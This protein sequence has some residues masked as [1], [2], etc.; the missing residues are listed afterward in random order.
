MFGFIKD[1]LSKIYSNFSSKLISLF[2][3]ETIDQDSL[4]ELENLL[5]AADLGVKT[6]RQ[7][8]QKLNENFKSGKITKG[9]DLKKA[10]EE[11]LLQIASAKKADVNSTV[12]LLVGINGS[13][14]TT[15]VGKLANKF[16]KEGKSVLLIAGDTFRAAATDQLIV[17]SKKCDVQIEVGKDKQDP[18]SVIFAGCERFKKESF[19][20]LIIDTAGR[21]Q[22]KVNLMKE[23]EKVKKVISKQLPDH[24]ICTLLTIDSMLGQNSFD[25]A[26]VFNE[27]TNLDGIILTKMDGTGKAGIAFAIMQELNLPIAYI[28]FGEEVD[29]MKQFD[30]QEY[31][32]Q[33]MSE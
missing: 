20:I 29:K 13:G 8:I 31:V 7:I 12:F 19:D 22:T 6:T 4:N 2:T 15:F 14:K 26:K 27:S 10:L 33:L 32:T 3:K 23:L 18:A 11:L 5:I 17:W 28:S 16:K 25:Q 21:L 1:K 9:A 24:K 30:A